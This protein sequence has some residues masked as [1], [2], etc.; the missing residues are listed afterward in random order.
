M[1]GGENNVNPYEQT[2]WFG[3]FNTP[4]VW[5]NTHLQLWRS[6]GSFREPPRSDM[7]PLTY[8]QGNPSGAPPKNKALLR[9]Y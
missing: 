6:S 2:G 7:G 4:Y 3:G 8:S 5:F 9:V 1:D